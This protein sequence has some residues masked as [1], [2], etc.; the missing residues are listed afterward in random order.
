MQNGGALVPIAASRIAAL[1]RTF[2]SWS[3]RTKVVLLA[4]VAI[5]GISVPAAMAST[6][7]GETFEAGQFVANHTATVNCGPT[8]S[9]PFTYHVEGTAEGPHPGMFVEDGKVV[10]GPAGELV[11]LEATFTIT[12]SSGNVSGEKHLLSSVPGVD[13]GF[14]D[15]NPSPE[16]DFAFVLAGSLCYRARF[17]GGVREEG[18]SSLGFAHFAH[19]DDDEEL[20]FT[21][22]EDFVPDPTV[23]CGAG[24][25]EKV[26]ICHRPAGNPS[27]A[28]TIEVG[29]SAVAHHLA[30]GDTPGPC[31]P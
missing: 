22:F 25:E 18:L 10:P 31:Q 2:H 30:H 16:I 17:G 1:R 19:G 3:T 11:D 7:T 26:T 5:A 14:C 29:S 21:F 27:N 23:S 24:G 8:E 20:L 9:S 4:S 28:H 15:D 12:S 6:L 13:G